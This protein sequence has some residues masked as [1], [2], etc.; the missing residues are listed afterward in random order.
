MESS[1]IT[2]PSAPSASGAARMG[3]HMPDYFQS[4]IETER[5]IDANGSG[6]LEHAAETWVG[7]V[8]QCKRKYVGACKIPSERHSRQVRN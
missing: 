8:S 5:D 4:T 3:S 2:L 7:L 6:L 1:F